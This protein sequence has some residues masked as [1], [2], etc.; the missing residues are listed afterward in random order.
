VRKALLGRDHGTRLAT[1]SMPSFW[2]A[3]K[4][5]ASLEQEKQL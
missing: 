3:P 1:P 4:T 2:Q 5:V